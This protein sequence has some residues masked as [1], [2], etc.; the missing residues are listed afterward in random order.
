[1]EQHK[2][3]I[4]FGRIAFK[5]P[6]QNDLDELWAAIV[7]IPGLR[8][9]LQMRYIDDKGDDICVTT[10]HELQ[11]AIRFGNRTSRG[12]LSLKLSLTEMGAS[13]RTSFSI[14]VVQLCRKKGICV[15][16]KINQALN[17]LLAEIN[18]MRKELGTATRKEKKTEEELAVIDTDLKHVLSCMEQAILSCR[19]QAVWEENKEV[20]DAEG[21]GICQELKSL[22][23]ALQVLSLNQSTAAT[24]P[25]TPVITK[26]KLVTTPETTP[27]NT[28]PTT[29][30]AR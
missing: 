27:T 14:Q 18:N 21:T 19:K 11:E 22:R 16:S 10:N 23:S 2:M 9:H 6:I 25:A 20:F 8:P 4:C 13:I 26:S 30:W 17:S 12:F 3:E 29:H 28:A 7:T 15:T 1:M 5:F 24:T